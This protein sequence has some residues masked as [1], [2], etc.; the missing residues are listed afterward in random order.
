[1]YYYNYEEFVKDIEIFYKQSESFE[2]DIIL[3][4]ARGGV[5]FGHFLAEKFQL[6]DLYTLNSIHYDETKKLDSVEVFNI[7]NLPANKKVL[8]VDDIADSGES[9]KEIM[10]QLYK[11]YPNITFKTGTIFYKKNSTF[12]PD[13]K[14][15]EANDWIEFFWTKP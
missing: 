4:I 9:L 13:F 2:P 6:R 5:T 3:A 1:M 15:K 12:M 11:R 7:P 10:R 8:I 14:V